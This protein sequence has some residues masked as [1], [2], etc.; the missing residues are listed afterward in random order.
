MKLSGTEHN[1]IA[2]RA[3]WFFD[4]FPNDTNDRGD[5]SVFAGDGLD[6]LN[7]VIAF[8]GSHPRCKIICEAGTAAPG[9]TFARMAQCDIQDIYSVKTAYI[10]FYG[11]VN[12]PGI[13]EPT[14]YAMKLP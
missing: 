8:V 5:S 6:D 13:V 9:A 7:Q 1:L 10:A 3:S 11:S 14:G 4:V 12:K 2:Q